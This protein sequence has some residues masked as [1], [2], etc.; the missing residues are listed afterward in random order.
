MG[1]SRARWWWSLPFT[2]YETALPYDWE[3]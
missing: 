2:T 3:K 1:K